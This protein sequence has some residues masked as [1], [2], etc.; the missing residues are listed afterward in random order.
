MGLIN[1]FMDW[2]ANQ[3]TGYDYVGIGDDN[4]VYSNTDTG[5]IGTTTHYEQADTGYPDIVDNVFTTRIT[6][7]PA[8][9]QFYWNEVVVCTGTPG[10]VANR[11]VIPFG[12]KGNVEWELEL[13]L[14]LV[15]A[16]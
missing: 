3:M 5:L 4:T 2:V 16:E 12:E 8:D 1:N 7:A 14:T 15:V 11:L 6:V 10:D 13:E 9:A